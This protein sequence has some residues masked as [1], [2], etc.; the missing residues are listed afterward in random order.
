MSSRYADRSKS[1]QLSK[2][3]ASVRKAEG[4]PF[5]DV[6]SSEDLS[7]A[8]DGVVSEWRDRVF[9]PFGNSICISLSG[10]KR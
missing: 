7:H 9:S 2:Q 6:F 4:L 3:L 1:V 5:Q 8:I 10:V